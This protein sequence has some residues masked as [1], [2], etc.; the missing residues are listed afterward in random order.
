MQFNRAETDRLQVVDLTK[1]FGAYRA[2]AFKVVDVDLRAQSIMTSHP[3]ISALS[4]A[5]KATRIVH[6]TF[7]L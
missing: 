1:V 7:R 6:R 2:S 5:K 4:V 3:A